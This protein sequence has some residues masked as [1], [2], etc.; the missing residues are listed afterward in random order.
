M[1][2]NH[3]LGEMTNVV[4]HTLWCARSAFEVVQAIGSHHDAANR[5]QYKDAVACVQARCQEAMIIHL[6]SVFEYEREW[7][8]NKPHSIPAIIKHLRAAA[9]TLSLDDD[10]EVLEWLIHRGVDQCELFERQHDDRGGLI[11]RLADEI[12]DFGLEDDLEQRVELRSALNGI[13]TIRDKQLAHKDRELPEEMPQTTVHQVDELIR[14]GSQFTEMLY[15]NF[16]EVYDLTE[17]SGATRVVGRC[18]MWSNRNSL[19]Q[20]LGAVLGVQPGSAD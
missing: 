11:L 9:A 7:R 19:D 18:A 8:R 16:V 5:S 3:I 4:D 12:D 15:R 1:S 6:A 14:Y 10:T 13:K 20:L 2:A 17:D